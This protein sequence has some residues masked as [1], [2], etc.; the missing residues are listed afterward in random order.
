MWK[1][2]SLGHLSN[3]LFPEAPKEVKLFPFWVSEGE[4]ELMPC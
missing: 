1:T 3:T 2:N 4:E